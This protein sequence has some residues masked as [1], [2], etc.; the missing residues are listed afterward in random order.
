[1]YL[2]FNSDKHINVASTEITE[3]VVT[4]EDWYNLFMPAD[5]V[6]QSE[7]NDVHT[8]TTRSV[9]FELS[10]TVQAPIRTVNLE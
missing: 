10:Y 3:G 5:A 1:V 2:Q 7:R 8:W 9:C 6:H 4:I